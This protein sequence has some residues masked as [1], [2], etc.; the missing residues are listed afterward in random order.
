M[1]ELCMPTAAHTFGILFPKVLKKM[2]GVGGLE[3]TTLGFGD[4]CSTN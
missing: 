4:R 3:P 1:M 2:A